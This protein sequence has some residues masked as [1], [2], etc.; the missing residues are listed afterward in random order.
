MVQVAVRLRPLNGREVAGGDTEA[1]TVAPEDPHSV[2]VQLP[3]LPLDPHWWS[4]GCPLSFCTAC[5]VQGLAGHVAGQLAV[6]LLHL[7]DGFVHKTQPCASGVRSGSCTH[8]GTVVM[9]LSLQR[10]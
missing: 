4:L 3:R 2:Q 1:V 9:P 8:V 10:R 5:L 7:L 6:C